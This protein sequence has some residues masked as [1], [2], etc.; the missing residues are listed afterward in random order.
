VACQVYSFAGYIYINLIS[1]YFA[2]QLGVFIKLPDT[3][4]FHKQTSQW[5]TMSWHRPL[6][7][8]FIEVLL[9]IAL[10]R[11]ALRMAK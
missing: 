11:P 5:L 2:R 9:L 1:I 10:S 4:E 6:L 8:L 3:P 7:M